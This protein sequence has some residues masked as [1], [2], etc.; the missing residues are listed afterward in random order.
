MD[1]GLKKILITTDSRTK[2]NYVLNNNQTDAL[3]NNPLP[4]RQITDKITNSTCMRL[5]SEK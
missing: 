5:V 1:Q 3:E 4:Q 2:R